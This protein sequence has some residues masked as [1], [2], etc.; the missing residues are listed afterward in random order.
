[1][2]LAEISS[3]IDDEPLFISPS[4]VVASIAIH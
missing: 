3:A 1:M 2:L 4:T